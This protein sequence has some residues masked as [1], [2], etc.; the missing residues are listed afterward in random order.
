M[1]GDLE[2][3]NDV[4]SDMDATV[5]NGDKTQTLERFLPHSFEVSASLLLKIPFWLSRN[6]PSNFTE[7][8][9]QVTFPGILDCLLPYLDWI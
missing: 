6:E 4:S 9:G 3:Q 1:F 8:K 5:P 2:A 7:S